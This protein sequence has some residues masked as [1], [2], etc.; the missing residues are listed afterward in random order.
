MSMSHKIRYEKIDLEII[1]IKILITTSLL[2][3]KLLD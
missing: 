2:R 1:Y 3:R